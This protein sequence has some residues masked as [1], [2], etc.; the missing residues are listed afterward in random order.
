MDL[1]QAKTANLQA[2]LSSL[3]LHAR[4]NNAQGPTEKV[5]VGKL[6]TAPSFRRML[7]V[8]IINKSWRLKAKVQ[9]EKLGDN[10]FKF[11]FSEKDDKDSIFKQ[12]PWSFNSSLLIMQEWP[13][14]IA[15]QEISFATASF[16]VQIHGLPP[17]FLHK[18]TARQIGSLTGT[19]DE[20][21]ISNKLG[22]FRWIILCPAGY[23]QSR[24]N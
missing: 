20:S 12:R 13:E 24:E 2:A 11:S 5:L 4:D 15:L 1:L 18:E 8:D 19:V 7:L 10:V 3:S 21:S 6:L 17:A 9:V 23:F 22:I 14:Q 16:W